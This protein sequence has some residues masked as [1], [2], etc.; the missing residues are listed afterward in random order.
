MPEHGDKAF[1]IKVFVL[2]V[3]L[4]I[5]KTRLVLD[6]ES[7]EVGFVRKR[8]FVLVAR[9]NLKSSSVWSF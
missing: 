2:D 5:E 7:L 3:T 4:N 6:F 9:R 8:G 1:E